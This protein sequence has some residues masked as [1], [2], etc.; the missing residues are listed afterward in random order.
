MKCKRL[1]H[2]G[3]IS[4]TTYQLQLFFTKGFQKFICCQHIEIPSYLHAISLIQDKAYFKTVIKKLE[5][6]LREQEERF[7]DFGNPGYNAFNK[8]EGS[9]NKHMEQH[10]EN[11]MKNVLNEL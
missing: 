1:V 11:L 10:G 5:G 8:I 7:T 6:E 9:M 3:F 4:L 2:Y